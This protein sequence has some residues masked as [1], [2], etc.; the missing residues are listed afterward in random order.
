MIVRSLVSLAAVWVL[1]F[2]IISFAHAEPACPPVGPE[3]AQA[4]RTACG[5]I[6]VSCPDVP[7]CPA[8][9]A[10]QPVVVEL[11]TVE[12]YRPVFGSDGTL[13]KCRAARFVQDQ[14]PACE[15]LQ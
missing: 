2:L 13:K 6:H 3:C 11:V 1:L 12:C 5:N 7:E 10:A 15:L 4:C 8:C 9:P 14:R